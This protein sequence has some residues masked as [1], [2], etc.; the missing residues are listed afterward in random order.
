MNLC[1]ILIFKFAKKEK[2][3]FQN[4]NIL[5]CPLDWGLGH[6]SRCIPLI[7]Y[8]SKNNHVIVACSERLQYF[9]KI[10][11]P[12]TEVILLKG[13]IIQYIEGNHYLWHYIKEMPSMLHSVYQE[14][15]DICNL[16]KKYHIDCIISDNR[17]G[18]FSKQVKSIFMTHQLRPKAYGLISQILVQIAAIWFYRHYSEIWIPDNEGDNSY[19]GE[20]SQRL[21]QF[22]IKYIGILSRFNYN[23]FPLAVPSQILVLISG[24]EPQRTIFEKKIVT[25]LNNIFIKAI[26]VRGLPENQQVLKN[27]D[28]ILFYNHISTELLKRLILESRYIICRSGYSTLMDLIQLKKT[29]L[30]IPT[31]HQPE[32]E[33]L[34]ERFSEKFGFKTQSQSLMN[35]SAYI[36]EK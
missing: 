34:A 3:N 23:S 9:Y 6:A 31:P 20:L 26:I 19:S 11:L 10:E 33:Y 15:K 36:Q 22:N 21:P 30:L 35:L 17:Y 25:Q 29:A 32:Q 16:I 18:V 2:L 1:A 27:T 8:Y 24:P 28:T 4:R 14:H 5:I 12:D 7:R 13:K